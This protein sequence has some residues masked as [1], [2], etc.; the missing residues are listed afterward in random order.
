MKKIILWSVLAVVIGCAGCSKENSEVLDSNEVVNE[1]DNIERLEINPEPTIIVHTQQPDIVPTETIPDDSSSKDLSESNE[2]YTNEI[3]EDLK[4]NYENS[5][6]SIAPTGENVQSSS[7]QDQPVVQEQPIEQESEQQ[8]PEQQEPEQPDQQEQQEQQEL[9]APVA[10][11]AVLSYDPN[12]VKNQT[13][14][15]ITFQ[16]GFEYLSSWQTIIT[17]LNAKNEDTIEFQFSGYVQLAGEECYVYGVWNKTNGRASD[18]LWYAV[19]K[20]NGV[21][22][23]K[24]AE[25]ND[26]EVAGKIEFLDGS[27]K[28]LSMLSGLEVTTY[29]VEKNI[30]SYDYGIIREDM[31]FDGITD[32]RIIASQGAQNLYYDCWLYDKELACYTYNY[33]LSELSSPKFDPTTRK[34]TSYTHISAHEY[35]E[36]ELEFVDGVLIRTN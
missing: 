22:F 13:T 27:V 3:T 1:S 12:K 32:V 24:H 23:Q 26:Y 25:D 11:S 18:A 34:I 7:D 33:S 9:G 29:S 17:A 10:I 15:G 8:E 20:N 31:N 36:A 16:Q 14:I 28:K 30:E 19:S 4:E 6:P 2:S 21:I 35:D 5:Q